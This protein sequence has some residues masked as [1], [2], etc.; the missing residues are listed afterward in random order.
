MAAAGKDLLEHIEFQHAE[1]LNQAPG[2]LEKALKQGYRDQDDLMLVSDADE[3]WV[4]PGV[5]VWV[6]TGLCS[7]GYM[8]GSEK[9]RSDQIYQDLGASP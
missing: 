5:W 4:H 8:S 2:G 7:L 6:R 1:C 9:P 3:Q